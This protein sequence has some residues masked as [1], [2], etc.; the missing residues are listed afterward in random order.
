MLEMLEMCEINLT[1]ATIDMTNMFKDCKNLIS[2]NQDDYTFRVDGGFYTFTQQELS[3]LK[4]ASP[5]FTFENK[6]I[7]RLRKIVDTFIR[8]YHP[9]DLL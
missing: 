8:V 1:D 7:P 6:N 9:E 5:T 4:T 3:R 2:V